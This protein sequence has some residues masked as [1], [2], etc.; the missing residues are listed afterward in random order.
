MRNSCFLLKTN[1]DLDSYS[2]LK[3]VLK[4]FSEEIINDSTE[5]DGIEQAFKLKR[6]LNKYRMSKPK[7]FFIF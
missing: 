4:T 6:Y 5:L 1:W 7:L 2:N 3:F